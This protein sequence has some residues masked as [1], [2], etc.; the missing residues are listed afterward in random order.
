MHDSRTHC[1]YLCVVST[2]PSLDILLFAINLICKSSNKEYSLFILQNQEIVLNQLKEI[3]G[4]QNEQALK[5]AYEASGGDIPQAITFLTDASAENAAQSA[6]LP[7]G[8]PATSSVP[9]NQHTALVDPATRGEGAPV[10]G[11][12]NKGQGTHEF[13]FL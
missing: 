5:H 8:T 12:K 4:V 9:K 2:A 11:P 10:C 13:K 3:T 1:L 6:T 7:S